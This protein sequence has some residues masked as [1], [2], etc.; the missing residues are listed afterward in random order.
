MSSPSYSSHLLYELLDS[1]NHERTVSESLRFLEQD[2]SD[3]NAHFCIACAYI[4]QKL[5]AKARPHVD[6]LI[7]LDPEASNAHLAAIFYYQALKK[8]RMVKK[9]AA[10]GMRLDPENPVFFYY[11]AI[12]ETSQMRFKKARSF[13]DEALRLDPDDTDCLNLKIRLSSV[14]ETSAEDSWRRVDELNDALQLDPHDSALHSSLGDVYLDELDSP[15]EAEF[16]FREALK[17]DPKNRS[18]QRDL[19]SAVAKRNFLYR[20]L[21]IPSRTFTWLG[22]VIVGIFKQPW[23]LLFLIIG[24]KFVLAFIAW[25]LVATFLFWP[26][27]KVYEWLLVSELKAGTRTSMSKMKLWHSFQRRPRWLR[28]GLFVIIIS[29][30]YAGTFALMAI[31]LSSGFGFLGIAY[32]AHFVVVLTISLYTASKRQR[33]KRKREKTKAGTPV[34]RNPEAPI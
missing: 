16:H 15:A 4:D 30:L 20:L 3:A 27:G 25:L 8:M 26:A 18:N 6:A 11:A 29:G 1:G 7:S 12:V 17:S 2:P 23:R 21:S 22:Y 5:T 24:F 28:F 34:S 33:G 10:E 13:I 19:F 14:D 9:H 32:A 31:P